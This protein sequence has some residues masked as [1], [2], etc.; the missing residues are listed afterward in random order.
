MEVKSKAT[1]MQKYRELSDNYIGFTE[2]ASFD[3]IKRKVEKMADPLKMTQTLYDVLG[4]EVFEAN[5]KLVN[6]ILYNQEM[7]KMI[8]SYHLPESVAKKAVPE[9]YL[10]D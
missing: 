3:K 2:E 4:E 1:N 8:V 10:N 9:N 5:P 7:A 6:R